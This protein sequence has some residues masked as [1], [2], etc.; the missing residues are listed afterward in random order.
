AVGNFCDGD[1]A[2]DGGCEI[3]MVRAD[4]RGQCKLQFWRFGDPLPR[5][6]SGPEGLRDDNVGAGQLAL[7]DG[8]WAVLVGGHDECVTLV[9]EEF[10]QTKFARNDTKQLAGMEVDRLRLGQ[11]LSVRIA[12]EF[13]DAAPRIGLWMTI[14]GV[15]VENA[16]DFR[17]CIPPYRY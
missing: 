10:A 5:Q 12:V 11:R 13:G 1:A 6:I 16:Q 9:F 17:H 3:D 15:V 14:H 7:E 4:S 2:L 8:A